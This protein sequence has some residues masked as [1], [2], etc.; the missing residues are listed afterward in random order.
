MAILE[1]Q[2]DDREFP[3]LAAGVRVVY[4]GAALRKRERDYLWG[5]AE[6]VS[7]GGMFIATRHPLREGSLVWLEFE[8]P[9]EGGIRPVRAKALVCWRRRWRQPRGMGVRFLE[10]ENLGQ[11]RLESWIEA[12]LNSGNAR[13]GDPETGSIL[14]TPDGPRRVPASLPGSLNR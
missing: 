12:V 9:E 3:R 5:V 11:R 14:Q 6:N 10:F 2:K 4:R 13:E 7:L 8:I 1:S